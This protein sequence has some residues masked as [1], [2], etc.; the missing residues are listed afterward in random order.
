[1][2]KKLRESLMVDADSMYQLVQSYKEKEPE[3]IEFCKNEGLNTRLYLN[4]KYGVN[5]NA[6][7]RLLIETMILELGLTL[8][9][10]IKRHHAR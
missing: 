9:K 6:G 1:M 3:F 5:F 10:T 8:D 2:S 4:L 7:R